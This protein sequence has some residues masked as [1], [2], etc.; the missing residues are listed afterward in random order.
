MFAFG[1]TDR[2]KTLATMREIL[3]LMWMFNDIFDRAL[4]K[5]K[6]KTKVEGE[7]SGQQLI[8]GPMSLVS[9]NSVPTKGLLASPWCRETSRSDNRT[10]WGVL[11]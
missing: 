8:R 10:M 2:A 7:A 9:R 5:F 4:A 6:R 1:K 3:D 11:P